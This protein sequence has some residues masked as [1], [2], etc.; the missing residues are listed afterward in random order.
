MITIKTTSDHEI[1]VQTPFSPAMRD[2]C[3]SIPGGAWDP[4]R[5]AWVYPATP[6]VALEISDRF[7]GGVSCADQEFCGL[8][9]RGQNGTQLP[10][11][12]STLPAVAVPPPDSKT[13]CRPYQLEA[14]GHLLTRPANMLGHDMG[15]GK[16]KVVV[17]AVVN[18]PDVKL[19]LVV[20]PLSVIQTWVDEFAKHAATP[21]NVVPLASGTVVTRAGKAQQQL[22]AHRARQNGGDPP[23]LVLV[24]N[25]EAV[26][27]PAFAKFA[28]G[29]AWDLIGCDEIQKIKNHN[30]RASKFMAQ[31][32]RI[33]RRRVGLSG[34]PMPHGPFDIFGSFRFLDVTIL[35]P[36]VTPFKHRYFVM[37]GHKVNGRPVEIVGMQNVDEFN[38]KVA[39]ITHF[40]TKED[41]G[42]DLPPVVHQTRYV[43]LGPVA[44]RAYHE[45]ERDFVTQVEAGLITVA[46]AMVLVGK[47]LQLTSGFLRVDREETRGEI[48]DH[49]IG[50]E[51]ATALAEL[52]DDLPP[53]EPVVVFCRFRHD[54]D[55]VAEVANK[56]KRLCFKLCGGCNELTE[57][58]AAKGGQVLAVQYQAGSV[59]VDLTRA[60]YCCFFSPTHSLGDY[61]QSLARLDRPGQTRSVTY[62]HIL[63]KDTV[64]EKVHAALQARQEVIETII[65]GIR[66]EIA[67]ETTPKRA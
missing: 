19:V 48:V 63:A 62:I 33:A 53:S 4:D 6:R 55:V 56:N 44:A 26:W 37:G 12:V 52:L 39:S 58:K 11:G 65:A 15:V 34:T 7:T 13:D 54:L 36:H 8:V 29:I 60:A 32:A 50:S 25:Y 64:D 10:D 17:D 3:K 21:V 66:E 49:T 46:N 47:Q 14:Y 1:T 41:A 35:G 18:L 51:K 42:L 45:L 30:G 23:P 5:R 67:D 57:W 38:R 27:R 59:G 28:Q 43:E 31:L 20:C 22:Q 40:V 2:A 61:R 9:A 16:T 24:I